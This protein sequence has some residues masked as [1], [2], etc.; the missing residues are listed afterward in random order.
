MSGLTDAQHARRRDRI[1]ASEMAAV[2]GHDPFQ[3]PLDVWLHKTGKRTFQDNRQTWAMRMGTKLEP[4]IADLFEEENPGVKLRSWAR[5]YQRGHLIS[6]I[7]R[8]IQGSTD[9]G[10]REI[11]QIKTANAFAKWPAHDRLPDYYDIQT[12][13]EM[14]CSKR[15]RESLCVLQGGQFY[16][17]WRGLEPN[18]NLVD[19]I[20]EAADEFMRG[21][22]FADIPPEPIVAEDLD[23]LYGLGRLKGTAGTPNRR[24]RLALKE[25]RRDKEHVKFLQKR[26]EGNELTVK[27]ALADHESFVNDDERPKPLVTWKAD[28]K[29]KYDHEGLV[30]DIEQTFCIADIGDEFDACYDQARIYDHEVLAK[31]LDTRLR[32]LLSVEDDVKV[33]AERI[34]TLDALWEARRLRATRRFLLKPPAIDDMEVG[35]QF[36]GPRVMVAADVIPRKR[37]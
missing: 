13:Q 18:P 3:T 19:A 26:I 32:L 30:G 6:H 29:A 36:A 22:V 33:T 8:L 5:G 11:V 17:Q 31:A 27:T 2:C 10:T 34:G 9:D 25:L 37:K 16:K 20:L 14:Y 15:D 1:G 4:V 21:R 23:K 24:V 35:G 7:D 12:Q 28:A